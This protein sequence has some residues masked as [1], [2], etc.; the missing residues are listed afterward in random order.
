[1]ITVMMIMIVA[2]RAGDAISC[3][4]ERGPPVVEKGGNSVFSPSYDKSQITS[5]IEQKPQHW[6]YLKR[7][8]KAQNRTHWHL[9]QLGLNISGVHGNI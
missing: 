5:G 2:L 6:W 8:R 9:S 7:K 1:M 4:M 3:R